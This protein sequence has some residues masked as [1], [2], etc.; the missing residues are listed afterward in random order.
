MTFCVCRVIIVKVIVSIV[1]NLEVDLNGGYIYFW[2][3]SRLSR[4][5]RIKNKL[6]RSKLIIVLC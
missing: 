1:F 6:E 4:D 5:G 3:F 2:N